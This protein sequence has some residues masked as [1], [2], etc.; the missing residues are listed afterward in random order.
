MTLQELADRIGARVVGD[1]ATQVTGVAS[2]KSARAGDLVFIED[3]KQLA[4]ALVSAGAA[5]VAGEFAA[6][7]S[8]IKPLLIAR[9]PKLAFA[10]AAALL[11]PPARA[12]A[13]VHPAAVVQ[14]TAKLGNGVSVAPH[15][16]VGERAVVGDNTRIG[17]GAS[18]G[19]GVIIGR[20]CVIEANVSIYP[21][22]RLGDRVI[23]HAGSVL[24]SD[25]FGYVR[26]QTTGRYEK[27]PQLGAL[28]IA[29][30]VEIGAN[31]TI[32][33]GAL[34]ATVIGPGTK[35]DNLVQVAHNVRIG[36]NVVIAAECGISGSSVVEDNCVLAGQVGVAD[37][38]RI[39]EGVILGAQCG[40]PSNKIVRGRGVVFWG[41]PPRPLRQ[42]LKELAV[43]ARLA[44]KK[45]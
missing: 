28:D 17:P 43:L 12:E 7:S 42:Y 33:R 4:N 15:A 45:D 30:D 1:G 16:V 2:L 14:E 26:D 36:R 11:C 25:G 37:H 8:D 19:S 10:R 22:V 20:D 35:I 27:F 38:V 31:T 6:A 34:D 23:I 39:E 18:V 41:T 44:K 24:G 40:V 21:G 5:V 29:D 13:G 32:D 3:E 9:Q